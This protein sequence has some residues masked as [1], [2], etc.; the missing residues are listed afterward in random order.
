MKTNKDDIRALKANHRLEMVMQGTGE[1]FEADSANPDHWKSTITPGLTV[2][3]RRQLYEIKRP[4]MDTEAGDVIAWLRKR[5]TWTFTQALKFLQKRPLD[6]KR[7][8]AAQPARAE[9]FQ[10]TVDEDEEKPLDRWQ[11]EALEIAGKRI[12]E[13]FTWGWYSLVTYLEDTRIEP[14][15]AP[16]VT[17]CGRCEKRIDWQV[18]K[19]KI[20]VNE[21]G[22]HGAYRR[23]H[24]G[25]L[26]IL[27][28]SVKHPL[29]P[30][31]FGIESDEIEEALSNVWV[32]EDDGVICAACAWREYDFQIALGL[33][34]TSAHRREKAEAKERQERDQARWQEEEQERERLEREAEA[35]YECDFAAPPA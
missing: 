19:V 21:P 8:E 33:V 35:A 30:W 16:G 28:Y 4:G 31:D 3:I 5:Y 23:G 18:E 20:P 26:P 24:V 32:E 25:A 1:N 14:T 6:P 29:K 22:L 2:D 27:A 34:K 15:H 10:N 9:S 11:E 7:S 17:H 12:R 13:Y